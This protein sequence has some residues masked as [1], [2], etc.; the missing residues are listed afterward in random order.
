MLI[1]VKNRIHC[2]KKPP[3]KAGV[4]VKSTPHNTHAAGIVRVAKGAGIVRVAD[5]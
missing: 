1:L 4:R 2:N 5:M 3:Q